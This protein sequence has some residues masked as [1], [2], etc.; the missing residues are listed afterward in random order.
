[1]KQIKHCCK[2]MDTFLEDKRIPLQYNPITREYSIPL[3]GSS[4]IQLIFYCPWCGKKLPK[5]L[6]E[7]FFEIL[8]KKYGIESNLDILKNPNL[9]QE[10]K[11]DEWWK[12]RGL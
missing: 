12:K 7:E 1:M 2:L 8:E 9:P 11:S 4:A 10:F 3:K 5:D 6:G